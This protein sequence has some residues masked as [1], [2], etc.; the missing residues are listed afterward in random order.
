MIKDIIDTLK[1]NA[2]LT[3]LIKA[4]NIVAF[5]NDLAKGDSIT[6]AFKPL[7]NNGIIDKQRLELTIITK[8]IQN[9]VD[10]EEIIKRLIITVGDKQFNNK[11]IEV[12]LNGG[13]MLENIETGTYHTFL[14]FDI[15]Q[16]I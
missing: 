1:T 9:N 14:Y 12:K 16:R 10:C 13:G 2:E 6:Y 11:I 3:A 4:K 8:K 15:T 7:S 5:S